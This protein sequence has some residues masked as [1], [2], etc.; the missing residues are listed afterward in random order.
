MMEIVAL[1]IHD[2]H[3]E[4]H[5]WPSSLTLLGKSAQANCFRCHAQE[6]G[7]LSGAAYFE[8]VGNCI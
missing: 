8:K 4:L 7:S 3:G 1:D 5:G 2:A 6:G